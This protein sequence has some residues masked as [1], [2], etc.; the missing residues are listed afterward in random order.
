M[1]R[2]HRGLLVGLLACA[3]VLAA[4]STST[5]ERVATGEGAGAQQEVAAPESASAGDVDAFVALMRQ[6]G[7]NL[8]YNA[9]Q[10]V[11]EL[12]KASDLV[13]VGELVSA[14]PGRSILSSPDGDE[15]S[16]E[17]I[18]FRV[19]VTEVL[20][21]RHPE[22]ADGKEI[23]VEWTRPS[24]LSVEDYAS[25]LPQGLPV[26]LALEDYTT[27]SEG[28][29]RVNDER[30]EGKQILAPFVEGFV[31]RGGDGRALDAI[32][33]EYSV[34]TEIGITDFDQLTDVVRAEAIRASQ[35]AGD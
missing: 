29:A 31:V 2:H 3:L 6:G 18:M 23:L 25:R 27:L 14:E 4:C 24:R 8:D 32:T 13:V 16:G 7:V 17:N 30:H 9:F 12:V 26:L 34:A 28:F 33:G 19:A 1:N 22:W 5:D 11:E 20:G 35:T 15:A 21:G 10:S